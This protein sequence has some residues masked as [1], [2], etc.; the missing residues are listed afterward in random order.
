[1]AFDALIIILASVLSTFIY[2]YYF[3]GQPDDIVQYA[4]LGTLVAVLFVTAGKIHDRYDAS[5]LLNFKLQVRE[6]TVFWASTFLLLA[7]ASYA[8]K[9]G[10]NFSRGSTLFFAFSGF[11]G[12]IAARIL[13]RIVLAD[14]LAVRRFSGRKIVL[15][16]DEYATAN[17]ETLE[18]L[19][20]HGLDPEHHFVLSNDAQSRKKVITSAIAAVRGSDIGEVV[21]AVDLT[22]WLKLKGLIAKLRVL[23]IPV[24]LFPVGPTS[25]LFQLPFHLIG[26][27]VTIELQRGP[28]TLSER[29]IKR[30]LD[31]VV[32][33]AALICLMPLFLFT[34]IAIKF[35][36]SGPVLFRQRRYGFN[37]QLF[38]IL[39]FRSMSVLEDDRHLQAAERN[40]P[41]ITSVGSW[42][43]RTSIDEL[44][45]LYNVLI[46]E[47]SIVGPRPHA[48]AHDE[49]FDKLVGKYAYRQHV[50][51]G[52]TGWAQV[53]GYRGQMRTV[54]D[55][56]RRINLD[57]WY[58]DNW[59]L[60]LDIK[61]LFMTL[62]EVLRGENAY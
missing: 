33:S 54:S 26:E 48:M 27:N 41:R 49:H 59:S 24:K 32:A 51:P 42:L 6:V 14:G 50:K 9:I 56:E 37:G 5:E 29:A 55:V 23:P 4:A 46:G 40:D 22:S 57:L 8:M 52:I 17:S 25:D 13:W 30:M 31:I 44:P 15:I 18:V 35:D 34:A 43:R 10:A 19:S 38:Q 21:V 60:A 7:G 28:R 11:T 1:M 47:M 20:Q 62:I 53:H 58:I 2:H 45:Q 39:K 16:T 36:S 61:I 3:L 12:L